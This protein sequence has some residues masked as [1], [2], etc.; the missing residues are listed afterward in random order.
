VQMAR[1]TELQ[2]ALAMEPPAE[3]VAGQRAPVGR[4]EVRDCSDMA[5]KEA[6]RGGL[7]GE[8]GAL[9]G[10][11]AAKGEAAGWGLAEAAA[12]AR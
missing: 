6:G 3:R 10:R 11:A 5:G 9:A 12:E 8:T 1:A 7:A 4:E 2:G